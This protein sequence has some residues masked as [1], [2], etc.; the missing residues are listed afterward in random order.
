MDEA[1]KQ[2]VLK[3]VDG[4]I[5]SLRSRV[6]KVI[7]SI[8]AECLSSDDLESNL[9]YLNVLNIFLNRTK[10]NCK[11]L[12]DFPNL[13]FE[14]KVSKVS[15]VV[16]VS[17]NEKKIKTHDVFYKDE[18]EKN[19]RRLISRGTTVQTVIPMEDVRRFFNVF[20][21]ASK[22][23][24]KCSNG[25][26]NFEE[27]SFSSYSLMKFT[28][29]HG[30]SEEKRMEWVEGI[31]EM[32]KLPLP[33]INEQIKLKPRER[34]RMRIIGKLFRGMTEVDVQEFVTLLPLLYPYQ[35][36]DLLDFGKRER[37]LVR[38]THG[39]EYKSD[40]VSLDSLNITI[41][42]LPE[43]ISFT[44]MISMLPV[45]KSKD[46]NHI[47]CA[48]KKPKVKVKPKVKPK[49]KV[50]KDPPLSNGPWS[51]RTKV[52]DG[53]FLRNAKGGDQQPQ[54]PMIKRE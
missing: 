8:K 35:S 28:E 3:E 10:E 53:A 27:M 19:L 9:K 48:N 46:I 2:D 6:F 37:M 13:I 22:N 34:S 39:G 23:L 14:D 11:Q 45:N 12:L 40:N 21:F 16:K 44:N 54:V 1:L 49:V 42:N 32:A 25:Y 26:I 20:I 17:K 50:V 36:R 38:G 43:Y 7:V 47:I 15:K 52:T 51:S 29:I 5:D 18:G 41:Q 4:G 33:R 24:E 30:D 31:K